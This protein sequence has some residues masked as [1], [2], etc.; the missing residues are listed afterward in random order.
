[1]A[2]RTNSSSFRSRT[3][4]R[5][6]GPEGGCRASARATTP[7]RKT[8]MP[9]V[10][11]V[12]TS[13]ASSRRARSRR[14]LWRRIW[15][16][17]PTTCARISRRAGSRASRFRSGRCVR[18]EISL[19]VPKIP[20][21]AK[22]SVATYATHDHEPLAAM[23]QRWE[24]YAAAEREGNQEA[25]IAA[26]EARRDAWK[27]GEYAGLP[28]DRRFNGWNDETHEALVRALF[29]SNSRMAVPHGERFASARRID[30]TSPAWQI[31]RGGR[32]GSMRRP[33]RCGQIRPSPKRWR[34]SPT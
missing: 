13:S 4:R 1:M 18:T 30:S 15:A 5:P 14:S 9:T 28:P 17:F 10:R 26:E 21:P 33:P 23:Y 19:P 34:A 24:K 12:I 2:T 32:A 31:P 25:H 8:A 11:R 7:R 3:R 22:R 6:R 20:C 16:W 29:S 27:F